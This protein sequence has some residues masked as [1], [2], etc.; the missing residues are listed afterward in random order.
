MARVS[1]A[2]LHSQSRILAPKRSNLR[3]SYLKTILESSDLFEPPIP[4]NTTTTTT[5]ENS[6]KYSYTLATTAHALVTSTSTSSLPPDLA[7][8]RPALHR[9]PSLQPKSQKY[10]IRPYGMAPVPALCIEASATWKL[11]P[12]SDCGGLE[13]ETSTSV[14]LQ[15][16]TS[17]PT[18]VGFEGRVFA[19]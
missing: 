9:I 17:A 16:G 3:L 5:L 19:D 18:P 4:H 2:L 15:V 1:P 11:S 6:R 10:H 13:Q 12:A 14:L 8:P 7:N